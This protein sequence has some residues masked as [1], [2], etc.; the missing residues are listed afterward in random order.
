MGRHLAKRL[1]SFIELEINSLELGDKI[2]SITRDN[3]AD[4]KKATLSGFGEPIS[5]I[6]HNMNLTVKPLVT[7]KKK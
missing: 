4:I 3:A 1:K 7:R 5:C 6:A 2:V